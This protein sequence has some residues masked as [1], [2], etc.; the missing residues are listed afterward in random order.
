MARKKRHIITVEPE[1]CDGFLRYD[2]DAVD[3]QDALNQVIQLMIK[4][5]KPSML[6]ITVLDVYEDDDEAYDIID[7]VTEMG[8]YR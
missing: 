3:E 1:W 5:A 6:D 7:A 2:T 4:N 8:S